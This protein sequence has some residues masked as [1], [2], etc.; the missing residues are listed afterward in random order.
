[1]A[2]SCRGTLFRRVQRTLGLRLLIENARGGQAL[3]GVGIHPLLMQDLEVVLA[4]ERWCA[5]RMRRLVKGNESTVPLV[6][7]PDGVRYPRG[8]PEIPG[9]GMLQPE[10]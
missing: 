4:G 7:A 6:I 2:D 5:E 3:D 8:E 1:M 9:L 10:V